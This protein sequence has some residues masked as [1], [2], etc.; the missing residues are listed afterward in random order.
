MWGRGQRLGCRL[1]SALTSLL[2]VLSPGDGQCDDDSVREQANIA[3]RAA[4]CYTQDTMTTIF[5]ITLQ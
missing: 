4:K 3:L 1:C 5:L 2:S